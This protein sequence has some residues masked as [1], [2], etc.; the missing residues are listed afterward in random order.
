MIGVFDSGLG[1]LAALGRLR[2]RLPRADF[3]YFGDTANLP[4]GKKS[5]EQLFTLGLHA[6]R[7]LEE[8]GCGA[9]LAACGTLSTTVLP[10]LQKETALPLYGV[11]TPAVRAT[12]RLYRKNGGNILLLATEASLKSG[13]FE[14]E[15][16]HFATHG[17]LYMRACPEFVMLAEE[18]HTKKTDPVARETVMR[19]LL[20]FAGQNI[21]TVLLGCTHFSLLSDCIAACFPQACL[22]DAAR[23]AADAL[24]DSLPASLCEGRGRLRL[25][26]SKAREAEK[27][28]NI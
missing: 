11:L 8:E 4:Y 6:L 24:A 2:E 18:G 19:I 14:K 26:Y 21:R 15:I 12:E 9:L 28:T 17:C 13:A 20:P 23:L 10:A 22:V 25:L 3:L 27:I 1:G 7:L 16:L 5:R